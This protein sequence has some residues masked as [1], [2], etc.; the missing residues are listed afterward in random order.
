MTDSTAVA[1]VDPAPTGSEEQI[2]YLIALDRPQL[3]AAHRR[4]VDWCRVTRDQVAIELKEE[5]DVMDVAVKNHWATK[6]HAAKCAVLE[7]RLTFY[8]KIEAALLAG[9]VLVPN[10]DMNVFAIR[11]TARTPRGQQTTAHWQRFLQNPQLLPIGKGEYKNPEPSARQ[12]THKVPD[13]KGGQKDETVYW[14][15]EFTDVQFPMVLAKPM[16]MQRTGE[17]MRSLIFDEIGIA[18]DTWR[19]G[20]RADPM[21][22][23]RIRNPRT[24]RPA[25]TFFIGWYFDPTRL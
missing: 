12:L 22:L 25:V 20:S 14:P 11:T 7:K 21:V 23:G 6:R 9:Y 19:G 1:T 18:Q 13:G 15:D 17:A 5:Q 10:F 8:S 24:G 4:M 16:L 3:E 2:R